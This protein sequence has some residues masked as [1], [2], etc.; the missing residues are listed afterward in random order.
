VRYIVSLEVSTHGDQI[1]YLVKSPNIERNRNAYQ[2]FIAHAGN[3]GA[4]AGTTVLVEG[5]NISDLTW[6]DQD[7]RIAMIITRDKRKSIVSVDVSN[8]TVST[9]LD[10][11]ENI[12]SY[13]IDASGTTLAYSVSL[14]DGLELP[15]RS[16]TKDQLAAGYLVDLGG[17]MDAGYHHSTIYIRRKEGGFHWSAPR[18]VTVE[19]PFTH[20]RSTQ[21]AMLASL[22]MSPDGKRLFIAYS[23]SGIPREWA[24]TD[25]FFK[26]VMENNTL[27]QIMVLYDLERGTTKLALKTVIAFSKPRWSPDSRSLLINTHPPFGSTWEEENRRNHRNPVTGVSLFEVSMISDEVHLVFH[28]PFDIDEGPL[29]WNTNGDVIV[30][31]GSSA[32][33]RFRKV[34][35]SWQI[36]GTIVLPLPPEDI[37]SSIASNGK[38]IFGVRESVTTPE[39]LFE[40]APNETHLRLLTNINPQLDHIE[41]APVKTVRWTTKYGG[42]VTGLLF[43]P[44]DYKAGDRYPL[45]IQTKGNAGIFT[46]DSGAGHYP[47][48]APQPIASAGMMYLVRTRDAAGSEHNEGYRSPSGYPG[49]IGEA[50]EQM[51][52]WD[53]A[54]DALNHQGLIDPNKVGIIGFSR[55]GWQVEFDLVHAR[56]RYAAATVTDNA[57][58]SLSEY[59][60]VPWS[61]AGAE[62]MYGGPPYGKT[63]ENWRRYSISFNIEK[64]HAPLLMEE[65]G[66]SFKVHD[67]TL[68][69]LPLNLAIR[70]EI[71]KGLTRL[72]KPVEMYYYP[73]EQHQPDDPKARLASLQRNVDWYRFWLQGYEDPDLNKRSQYEGWR[74]LRVLHEQDL[75]SS[76]R[77]ASG[78]N[79][80][81]R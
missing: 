11:S 16:H 36:L 48:F 64:I 33:Q 56:T 27:E 54:V 46:C 70:Y 14:P 49:G 71:A 15:A 35:D 8:G 28:D 72:G 38:S 34:G 1:A 21:L 30:R 3:D 18:P 17:R 67:D 37:L 69:A 12:D 53:S 51:E 74:T 81:K 39:D 58:Y 41:F 68:G 61:T 10:S 65:M 19:N 79:P 29:A 13:T 32:L 80:G 59:W 24:T 75:N 63:L 76:V 23:A 50:A 52:V 60:L 44:P 9:L 4:A 5:E 22:S 42:N 66:D 26:T 31:T 47:S 6:I 57:E 55:T 40:Y 45:V 73:D 20:E 7:R 2:L 43:L 62:V 78:T 25:P 77:V